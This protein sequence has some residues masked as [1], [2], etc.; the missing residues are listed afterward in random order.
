MKI[1]VDSIKNDVIQFST[2]LGNGTGR[3]RGTVK[4]Q[5]GKIYYVEFDIEGV[6]DKTELCISD[7][8]ECDMKVVNDTNIFTMQLIDY[9][10]TGCAT[11]LLGDTLFCV[12][13]EYDTFFLQMK[14]SF[15]KMNIGDLYL[16]DTDLI[17]R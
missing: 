12:E 9:E 6:I 8:E 7:H 15:L 2:A 4:P 14:N 13:T 11:F 1:K 10:D 5:I 3:W 16:Y 17:A